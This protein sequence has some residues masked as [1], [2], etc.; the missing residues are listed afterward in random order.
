MRDS[1]SGPISNTLVR[2]G[3]PCSPNRSQNT[4][5]KFVGLVLEA[6]IARALDQ[7][8]LRLADRRDPG[9]VALDVGGEHRHAGPRE[10]FGQHLQRHGLAGAGRAGHQAV[11]VGEP[12]RQIFRLAAFADENLVV[13]EYV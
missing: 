5:G 9:Q 10:A 11:A 12:Q 6:E 13:L 8:I 4:T 3:W 2:I 7:E 1:S